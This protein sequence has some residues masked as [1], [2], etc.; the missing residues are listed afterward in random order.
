LLEQ[1][2]ED[3]APEESRSEWIREAC[4]ERL[5]EERVEDRLDSIEERVRQ[6]E[7][8]RERS[9]LGRLVG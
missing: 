9:L 7:Q 4:R 6:L 5:A 1:I 3:T 8:E 2:E